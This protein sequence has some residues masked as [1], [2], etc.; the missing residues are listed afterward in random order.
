MSKLKE[1]GTPVGLGFADEDGYPRRG[2]IDSLE[3]QVDTETDTV[4]L[5]ALV[6]NADGLLVPGLSAHVRFM[7]S[8]PHKAL[9]VAD[10]AVR[11]EQGQTYLFVVTERNV[12]ERRNVE[13]GGEHRRTTCREGGPVGR[14]LGRR[15]RP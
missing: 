5:R 9:L 7:T 3:Y 13:L 10:A 8:A 2:Q 12:V 6:P 14:G 15:Q 11:V 4:W 1:A